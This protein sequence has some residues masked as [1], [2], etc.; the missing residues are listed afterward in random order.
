VGLAGSL[1]HGLLA[2]RVAAANTRL[3]YR[4]QPPLSSDGL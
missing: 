2:L 4:R 3:T 1:A